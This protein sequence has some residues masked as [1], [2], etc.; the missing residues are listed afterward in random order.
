MS[1][2]A[3]GAAVAGLLA[4]AACS[5]RT[6]P[7][8][9][10]DPRAPGAPE[11][12]GSI[13]C[14]A[15]VKAGT[16][17]CGQAEL[18]PGARGYII[19]GG[20]HVNVELTSSNVTYDAG[21]GAF[22]FDVTVM[23]KIPQAMGTT[24][25]VAADTNGVRVI[26]ASGPQ[27]TA[28]SGD[29]SVSNADGMD[30]F[31]STNQPFFRYAGAALGAD[32]I[33]ST[34]ETSSAKNWQLHV[35]GT[36]ESFAFTLY[37]V[38]EVPRPD[39]WVDVFPGT[40]N[41]LTGDTVAL[42]DSVRTAVGTL[43]ADATVTWA[44]ADS[45]I[46]RVDSAGNVVGVAPGSTVITATAGSRTGSFTVGVCPKLAVGQAYTTSMPAA[47]SLCLGGGASGA[48]YVYMP[49]NL[50]QSTALS[51]F[52]LS[53][54]GVDTTL[55]PQ[56]PSP[57]RL[58]GG[59]SPLRIPG[60]GLEIASDLPYVERD[61]PR[62]NGMLG[63][64]AARIRRGRAGGIRA[65]IT[66]G[67]VPS[68]GDSMDLNT[69]SA[70]SA[71]PSV[72]RGVVRSVG[73]HLVIVAD[74]ANPPGGF[75]TAQYD[76]IATEFDS[77]AWPVDS[78]NFGAPTDVDGNG[79][80][81]AFFT[82][83]VNELSPQNS[84]SVV[85]GFFASKDIFSNDPA[86]GCTNSNMGEMFYM[87]VPD[88]GGVVNNNKRAVS[89]VRGNTTGTLGHE[90]QHMINA[91]RRGYVTGASSFEQGFLNEG[92]S[93][94]AEELMF[95]RTSG[96]T[97]K[98]NVGP[99][100]NAVSGVQLNSKR[101]NAYNAYA[102][103]NIGRFRSWLQRPDTTGAFKQNQNSLAVRGAI[104]AFLRYAADRQGG[105]EQ[106]FWFHLVNDNLQGTA[107]I[108]HVIGNNDPTTWQRDFITALY[109]D[110][111][112]FGVNA[113]YV[114]QSWNFRA[115]YTLLNGSYSL[116]QRPLF[117]N[118]PL[119]LTYS[120]GGSTAYTRFRVNAAAFG[121]VTTGSSPLTPYALV[122]MRTR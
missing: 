72:R 94:I 19:V 99:G 23:N 11:M 50:A 110:D 33:L 95:Y 12:V 86:D 28:G 81:V 54:V 91:F 106:D 97:P 9:P 73:Q 36:V 89:F 116:L 109:A 69:N 32:G 102:S 108:Q 112:A 88:T 90:F 48:E 20:Q 26:F 66:Q 111:N 40:G 98:S 39:G 55:K 115:L 93:H 21:T 71:N 78:A 44:S 80:V 27:V 120:G 62:L 68:V 85:L 51:A 84:S 38:T 107:N 76:S 47:A 75:T 5:D 46:A 70:C 74:T 119:T 1:P 92:L 121:R 4:L 61:L 77:I 10:T 43:V 3:F 2:A 87:L 118:T 14:T 41:V 64:P 24:D 31:T 53:A 113:E 57:T 63:N 96:M 49:M 22:A 17:S 37:V 30:A 79:H 103:Q 16:V 105:S 56:S 65:I 25:G 42:T 34:N 117:N 15:S 35:D 7:L 104:W 100:T 82:R 8:G 67:V 29:A 101:V 52:S 58:P 13:R 122:V 114:T 59:L 45:L 6:S 18:P 60:E 83:A